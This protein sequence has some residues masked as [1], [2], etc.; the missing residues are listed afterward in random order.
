MFREFYCGENRHF[1]F[2]VAVRRL[3]S[4]PIGVQ[5]IPPLGSGDLF[6][7]AYVQYWKIK[8]VK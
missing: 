3:D 4:K 1:N 2:N 7:G 5:Y 8:C 6:V